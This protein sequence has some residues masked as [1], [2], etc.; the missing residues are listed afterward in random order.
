MSDPVVTASDVQ[1]SYGPRRALNGLTFEIAAGECLGLLGPNGS[2]KT[3]L[4]RIL[5][6][7]LPLQS[8]CISV[9]GRD[10]AREASQVR[11]LLG[12]TFQ[13]P[14][15]DVRLTVEENLRCHGHIYGL[16]GTSLRQRVDEVLTQ[17]S[18]NDR[19]GSLVGELSGGLKRRV[20]LAKGILHRPRLLLLD[21]PGTGLDPAARL[22][23]WTLVN[24]Q[25]R[26]NGTTVLLTTHLMNE[27]EA[28]DSLVLMDR[29]RVVRSGTPSELTAGVSGERLSVRCRNV[30][31]VRAR[32]EKAVGQP[33]QLAG[34]QLCFRITDAAGMLPSLLTEF[35]D[36]V[37]AAEVARATLED[38]F[39]ELTGRRLSQDD[40]QSGGDIS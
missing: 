31:N 3:T 18:L 15:V 21:E 30:A 14:A 40:A 13:S 25:Q 17:F 4:F 39:L 28:C 24:E 36:E 23:F 29:G 12:V 34:D 9:F 35:H 22:Q 5:A 6:T 19:R 38:V 10:L 37:L 26:Q 2:G 33:A 16:S 8:G 27:A 1:H 20:E 32:L 7:L 11:R